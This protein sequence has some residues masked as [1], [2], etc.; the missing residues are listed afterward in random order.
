MIRECI[1][2]FVSREDK[3]REVRFWTFVEIQSFLIYFSTNKC[4]REIFAVSFDIL[5]IRVCVCVF[6]GGLMLVVLK[7]WGPVK[8]S[9][10]N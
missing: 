7:A 5:S 10:E 8:N 2:E 1:R 6:K 3:Q 4:W 9:I